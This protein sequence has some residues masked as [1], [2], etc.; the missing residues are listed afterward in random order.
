MGW[1]VQLHKVPGWKHNVSILQVINRPRACKIRHNISTIF[2]CQTSKRPLFCNVHHCEM[3]ITL[4]CTLV[5]NTDMPFVTGRSIITEGDL[6]NDFRNIGGLSQIQKFNM[7]IKKCRI[8][9]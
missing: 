6:C 2:E 4:K 8:S 3:D 7:R 9:R 5:Y 1:W